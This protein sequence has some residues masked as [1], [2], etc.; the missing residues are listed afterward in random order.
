MGSL[1]VKRG[2]SIELTKEQLKELEELEQRPIN[3]DDIPPL[4]DEQLARMQ[5]VNEHSDLKLSV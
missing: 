5:R 1:I 3:F 4:T 2:Q